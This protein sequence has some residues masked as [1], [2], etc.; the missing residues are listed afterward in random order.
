[1]AL[2]VGLLLGACSSDSLPP[3]DFEVTLVD[4]GILAPESV[5]AGDVTMRVFITG[6]AHHTLSFC[7]ATDIGSCDGDQ[8]DFTYT[9]LPV[10]ARD[11]SVIPPVTSAIV[12]GSGWDADLSTTLEP[13][14]YRMFCS[15]INHASYGM[16]R[17]LRVTD[18]S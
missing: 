2:A 17:V 10:D 15:I 13:G 6:V 9:R 11:P 16:D 5:P 3:V 14:T 18:A 8:I 7:P 12:L 4:Y 1:M